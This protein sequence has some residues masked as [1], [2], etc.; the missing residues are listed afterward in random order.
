MLAILLYSSIYA[1]IKNRARRRYLLYDYNTIPDGALLASGSDIFRTMQKEG[2]SLDGRLSAS[3][4]H[5]VLLFVASKGTTKM[6]VVAQSGKRNAEY[7]IHETHQATGYNR[8]VIIRDIQTKY[9]SLLWRMIEQGPGFFRM[10]PIELRDLF[11]EVSDIVDSESS[12]LELPSDI[13][14]VG[15]LRGRYCDLLRWF[16]LYGYPPKRRYLFL[17]GIVDSENPDSM[18]TIA[19]I[20]ALKRVLPYDVFILRGATEYLTYRP[21]TR[22]PKTLCG[23]I[24]KL[25]ARLFD[26]LPLAA[27]IN[28]SI[29]AVHSGIDAKM[30]SFDSIKQILRPL[31]GGGGQLPRGIIFNIPRP[32]FSGF[33]RIKG[34]LHFKL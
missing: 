22:F 18:E 14:I 5:S 1:Y 7:V 10:E 3:E 32:G 11:E 34:V 29:L 13:V 21:K 33:K 30:H 28:F 2:I 19:L 9:E 4:L 24:G 31:K 23:A 17:G 25:M 16:Q 20:A 6:P 8:L 27:L 12:L 26:T 15:D